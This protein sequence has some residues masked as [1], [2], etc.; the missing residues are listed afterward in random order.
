MKNLAIIPARA[1][2]KRLKDK[3]FIDFK[4]KPM[5]LHT[6]EA[7]L[8]TD[9]FDEIHISTNSKK[10]LQICEKNSIKVLFER[11][12]EYCQDDSDLNDVC[13]FV[14]ENYLTK[15]AKTFDHFCL[16]WA[17][18]PLRDETD[19]VN[20]FKMFD[21]ETNAVIAVTKFNLPVFCAQFTDK[22]NFLKMHFP[23][24][25]WKRSQEMPETICNCGSMAWVKT[26]A[27]LKEGVWMPSSSKG[28]FLNPLKAVDIDFESDLLMA[29]ERY[30]LLKSDIHDN[31][32]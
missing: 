31:N 8:K 3:N 18:S 32:D 4:G 17:T 23:D 25:F 29:N 7:A 27:F 12:D 9:I 20:A 2:S 26:N 28:Y 11:P 15:Y 21:N 1:G 5:F 10:I 30:N 13:R 19:I 14:I 6:Y 24:M 16:L 22:K